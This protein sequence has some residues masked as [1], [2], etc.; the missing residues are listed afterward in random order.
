M[1]LDCLTV[2]TKGDG[3]GSVYTALAYPVVSVT[4]SAT[5]ALSNRSVVSSCTSRSSK[6]NLRVRRTTATSA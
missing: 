2:L 1:H 6:S 4:S 5:D 3:F